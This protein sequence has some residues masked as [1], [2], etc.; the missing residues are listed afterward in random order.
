MGVLDRQK[1]TAMD[2][3][4]NSNPILRIL[5][6]ASLIYLAVPMAIFVIV[7]PPYPL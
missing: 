7:Y 1:S 4:L 5:L 2:Y 3:K 6:P